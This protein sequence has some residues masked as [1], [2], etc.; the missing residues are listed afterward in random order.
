MKIILLIVIMFTI[1]IILNKVDIEYMVNIPKIDGT[2][3]W[4]RD[5][6]CSNDMTKVLKNTLDDNDL[7]RT[8]DD[9]W[10]VQFPC[11]YNYIDN[12]IQNILPKHKNQRIFIIN[13]ADQLSS[14]NNIWKNL[15]LT[16]GREGAS[17][18]M[19]K[20]YILHN[21]IDMHFLEQEYSPKKIYI[22]KK[23][24]QRQQGLKITRNISDIYNALN[25]GFVIAQELLQNPYI[26]N[27]RKTN[28]RIYLLFVCQN[29][30][31][32]AYAHK[33]G[34]TNIHP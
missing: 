20:T 8:N 26:I 1:S 29:N 16:Y 9:N 11:N 21:S 27:D 32:S 15:V 14:K 10:I 13:N 6:N 4:K 23:N 18:L 30:E 34:F 33:E 12:E 17:K 22:L 28:M 3:K 31:I 7:K 19:P 5:D 2:I 25:D 24:I